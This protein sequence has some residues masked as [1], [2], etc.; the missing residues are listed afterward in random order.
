MGTSIL[1]SLT[2]D[3]E[4]PDCGDEG[5]EPSEGTAGAGKRLVLS[6]EEKHLVV[7]MAQIGCSTD[8]ICYI[9]GKP[10]HRNT[11]TR[12]YQPLLDLGRSHGNAMLRRTQFKKAVEDEDVKMLVWLGKQRLGQSE[13]VIDIQAPLPW[14][15]GD[16]D[17]EVQE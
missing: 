17:D 16:N 4:L 6:E 7:K 3:Y 10:A 5:L 1:N 8:E 11:L 9:M 12:W 2:L 15:Q 13:I 14:S